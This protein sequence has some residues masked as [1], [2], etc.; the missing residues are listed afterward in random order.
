[1]E[2]LVLPNLLLIAGT[3]RNS[4]KT[5]LACSI[6]KKFGSH[7]SIIAVKISP[8]FHKDKQDGLPIW[9]R[10]NLYI[11]E[12]TDASKSKDSSLMLAAGA[13]RS[14][15]V[16]ADDGQL[17]EAM[18][19]ILAIINPADLIIC[20]SGG[21][22]NFI[23]PGLFFLLNR[24]DNSTPKPES[25]KFKSICNSWITFDGVH[26]DF[27]VESIAIQNNKWILIDKT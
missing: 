8:H 15:F 20:E 13:Q 18:Q 2:S 25:V 11:I 17:P 27:S 26:F 1:M 19:K 7:H 3:G 12:E 10:E 24:K 5:T 6:I 14:F 4:G 9:V 21:L 16:M 23:T 22:R